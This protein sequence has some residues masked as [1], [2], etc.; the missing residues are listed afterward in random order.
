MDL[1]VI[2]MEYLVLDMA[3]R[4]QVMKL[5]TLAMEFQTRAMELLI[6]A[7]ERITQVLEVRTQFMESVILDIQQ[8]IPPTM[9]HPTI[10]PKLALAM[11]LK[12]PRWWG[13]SIST[14]TSTTRDK[15]SI[16]AT[17]WI[18]LENTTKSRGILSLEDSCHRR[19]DS[20]SLKSLEEHSGSLGKISIGSQL[21]EEESWSCLKRNSR[22]Q[23][24]WEGP[25]GS[26]RR[27]QAGG[28]TWRRSRMM[29]T[30]RRSPTQKK[31]KM[32]S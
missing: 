2:T 16:L 5:Q 11:R 18:V 1:P 19:T 32:T 7:M 28:W 10:H 26:L 27:R 13:Q 25:S 20:A 21:E 6:L 17:N 31:V 30:P 3:P 24:R 14:I 22:R 12:P 9:L 15:T 23:E 4:L 29:R 8:V